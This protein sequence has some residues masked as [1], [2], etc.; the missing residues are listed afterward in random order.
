MRH[1]GRIYILVLGCTHKIAHRSCHRASDLL[2]VALHQQDD[3]VVRYLRS[4][5]GTEIKNKQVDDLLHQHNIKR[6]LTCPHTSHQNGK[7]ERHI[8][9]LFST[10]RTCLVDSRLPPKLS[11][12]LPTYT[13]VLQDQ[14]ESHLSSS[15]TVVHQKL[16]TYVHLGQR[17]QLKYMHLPER[18][19]TCRPHSR[20]HLS[21]MAMSKDKRATEC[22]CTIRIR[23]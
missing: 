10:V 17:V 12:L 21:A 7:A 15:A 22:C 16:G 4:D 1:C 6:E 9:I 3:R 18:A 2:S 23:L 11:Q 19:N 8:G 20:Q 13:T 14:A 5:N